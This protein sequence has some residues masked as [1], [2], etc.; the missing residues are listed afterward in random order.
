MFCVSFHEKEF[1]RGQSSYTQYFSKSADNT[2]SISDRN[3]LREQVGRRNKDVSKNPQIADHLLPKRSCAIACRSV[4]E[5][6]QH[7]H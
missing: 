4:N 5:L 3:L 1:S 6:E 7:P 2:H